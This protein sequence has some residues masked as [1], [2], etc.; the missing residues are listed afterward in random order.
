MAKGPGTER[1]HFLYLTPNVPID[2]LFG[3]SK[4]PADLAA[5][6][7]RAGSHLYV[8][9]GGSS[10]RGAASPDS[11]PHLTTHRPRQGRPH[12]PEAQAKAHFFTSLKRRNEG[13]FVD[14]S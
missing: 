3:G 14:E 12:K 4:G 5:T 11:S 2:T 7:S 8:G 10:R 13:A 1:D 9:A 6:R